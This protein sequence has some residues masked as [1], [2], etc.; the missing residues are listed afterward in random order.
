MANAS[1]ETVLEHLRH[2][3]G[4]QAVSGLSDGELLQRYIDSREDAAFAALMRRHGPMVLNVCRRILR[5]GQDAEDAFQATFF[6]LARKAAAIAKRESVGS[7][8]YGV[9]YRLAHKAKAERDRRRWQERRAETTPPDSPLCEAAW[10]ELQAVLDEEL[11]RLPEKYRAALLLCYLEGKSHEEA[12]RQLGWPV[13][14]VRTRLSRGREA[15]RGRLTRRGLD[16]SATAFATTLAANTTTA[17]VSASLFVTTFRSAQLF[18]AGNAAAAAEVSAPVAALAEAAVKAMALAKVKIAALMLVVGVVVAG[19][20]VL[21]HR[22]MTERRPVVEQ[23]K[24][25]VPDTREAGKPVPTVDTPARLDR[26]GDPLPPGAVARLGTV[27][28]RHSAQLTGGHIMA[29]SPDGRVFATGARDIIRVWNTADG[30]MLSEIRAVG[31]EGGDRYWGGCLLFSPDGKWLVADCQQAVCFFDPT[32]GQQLRRFPVEPVENEL[33]QQSRIV[34]LALSPD[35][36]HLAASCPDGAIHVWDLATGERVLRLRDGHERGARTVRFSPGGDTLVC[37]GFVG[38]DRW[39]CHWDMATGRLRKDLRLA[40][41]RLGAVLS[42]D[43]KVLASYDYQNGAVH[44][45]DSA[46]GKERLSLPEAPGRLQ[47]LAL[48]PQGRTLATTR[49]EV[50][51]DRSTVSLWETHT[52]KQLRSFSIPALAENHLRFAPDGR[53][54]VSSGGWAVYFW[55]TATRQRLLRQPAHDGYIYSLSFTPDGRS[56][57][58]ASRDGTV[59]LW[60]TATGQHLHA[61]PSHGRMVY[62][63]AV[64]PDGHTLLS[65]GERVLCLHDL[66][67]GKELRRFAIDKEPESPDGPRHVMLSL[68]LHHDGR[69]AAAVSGLSGMGVKGPN[70]LLTLWDLSTGRELLRRSQLSFPHHFSPDLKLLAGTVSTPRP[71]K[72][73]G[74]A[75]E[76]RLR[77]PLA[78]TLAV[79]QEVTTGRQILAVPQPGWDGLNPVFAP[80]GQTFATATHQVDPL[81]EGRQEKSLTIHLWE[82]TTGKERLAIASPDTDAELRYEA[83]AFAPDGRTLATARGDRTL[84]LWDIATG[85]DLLRRTGYDADVSTLA[86]RPDGQALAT[87]HDTS[88][89]IW[90]LSSMTGL[91][92]PPRHRA[93]AREAEVWW[94]DLAS[95]DAHRAHAA[96]W[97]MAGVPDRTI[98]LLRDRLRP[99]PA[100]PFEEVRRAVADLDS[101]Q[102]QRRLAALERLAAWGEQV[103]PALVQ[104]LNANPSPEQHRQIERLL[105][106][107]RREPSAEAVRALRAVEVLEHCGTPE[108]QRV[109]EVLAHGAPE[110]RLTFAAK[111]SLERVAKRTCSPSESDRMTSP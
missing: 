19:A 45:W 77:Q 33:K 40:F 101:D 23:P 47:S 27:R 59:R 9:A 73:L 81:A 88:I 11:A 48:A 64:L 109:L 51:S 74:E 56:L 30:K 72:P 7:W 67:T 66:R 97:Q 61:L 86:F 50:S 32:T 95:P 99:A 4:A 36:K 29:F 2:L 100:L 16:L 55:D 71:A 37:L 58:S 91:R 90:D 25:V 63:V 31:V 89:L 22:G 18:S 17:A 54:L 98:P 39:L 24:P 108:A 43:G 57:V 41:S 13:G 96:I 49:R 69:V 92:R 104:A 20:G 82:T 94:A 76:D 52:G 35:N 78:T 85:E 60:D 3:F 34:D 102:Y 12:A 26:F 75:L 15:L 14:T 28:L 106:G 83:L 110:A 93:G 68:G 65:G 21:T 103:E 87:A 62:R 6:V 46:T 70:N 79:L 42:E 84:Q 111:A 105:T 44:L 5:H 38:R 80:D 53:T 8:L 107:P 10:R 1:L